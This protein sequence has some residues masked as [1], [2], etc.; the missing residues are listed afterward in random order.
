MIRIRCET[1]DSLCL[2]EMS[3]FQGELKSRTAE[4]LEELKASLLTEGLLAPFFVWKGKLQSEDRENNW[5]LDGHARYAA[6][7][8]ICHD[9]G[10][11][12]LSLHK[13]EFPVVYIEAASPDEA[14]KALLQITSDYG[15]ITKKGAKEFCATI[16]EYRAPSVAMFLKPASPLNERVVPMTEFSSCKEDGENQEKEAKDNRVR[17][18]IAVSPSY[19]AMARELFNSISYIEVL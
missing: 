16:P 15:K 6:L 14:K 9:M 19:E 7:M 5:L 11:N 8:S 12:A 1:T 2:C 17:I 18:T 3:P 13:Q 4:Q 10:D